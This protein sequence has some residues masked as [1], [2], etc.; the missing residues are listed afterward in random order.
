MVVVV[1]AQEANASG[2]TSNPKSILLDSDLPRDVYDS[3]SSPLATPFKFLHR[4]PSTKLRKVSAACL[5]PN[6]HGSSFVLESG[7]V[8]YNQQ[9][10]GGHDCNRQR[11]LYEERTGPSHSH[12]CAE[13]W[14]DSALARA[15]G[16]RCV[17]QNHVLLCKKLTLALGGVLLQFGAGIAKI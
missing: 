17:E 7:Y 8:A 2:V 15:E 1:N 16:V 14:E 11:C 3:N 12:R 13:N 4:A 6:E 5:L 9:D 10:H